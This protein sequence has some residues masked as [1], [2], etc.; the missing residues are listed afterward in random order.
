MGVEKVRKAA[1]KGKY[2]KKCCRDNPRCKTCQV[3]IKRLEKQGAFQLDDA[4]L[5]RALAKARKW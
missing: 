5:K 2:K 1:K 4:G 3:V